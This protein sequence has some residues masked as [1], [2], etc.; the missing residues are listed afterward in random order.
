MAPL[1]HRLLC[2]NVSF[3]APLTFLPPHVTTRSSITTALHPCRSPQRCTPP[4]ALHSAAPRRRSAQLR[5]LSSDPHY[6][7]DRIRPPGSR[8]DSSGERVWRWSYLW[9]RS[10]TSDGLAA[11]LGWSCAATRCHSSARHAAVRRPC[12][13]VAADATGCQLAMDAHTGTQRRSTEQS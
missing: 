9:D 7:L 11:A 6:P 1:H 13:L 10:A 2:S 5:T 3:S 8:T 12:Q 4:P